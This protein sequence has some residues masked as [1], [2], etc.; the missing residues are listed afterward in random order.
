[1]KIA[2]VFPVMLFSIAASAQSSTD[3]I[4][5]KG[6]ES[7]TIVGSMAK[8]MPGAGQYIG[9][10]K[11]AQLNQTNINNVLR[12]IPG[13]NIRDE[14]GFGLRP[15]IGLR[16]TPVNRS[17]KITLMEDGIL[18]APAP[19]ADPSAY[20]FPTFARMHGIEVLKGSS[21]IKYGPYTIGGAINLLSTVIPSSFKGFAQLSYGSF[22]TNQQRIWLGNSSK[23]FDYVF[24]AN[25]LAS[26]GFKKLS[27]GANTGFDRRDVMLKLRWHTDEKAKIY[28]ALS[29]KY[30]NATEESNETYLGLIYEDYKRNPFLRY[31]GTQK[32]KLDLKHNHVSLN[33]AIIPVKNL[34][35]HTTFYQNNTYRDWARANTFGGQSIN[36]ILGDPA[37]HATSYQIMKGIA[38]GEIIYQN[39]PRT[40]LALGVQTNAD[41][42]F[43]TC[44][45][46]HKLQLGIRYH[47]D[48]ADRYATFATYQMTNGTLVETDAGVKGNQENQVRNANSLATFISYDVSY[49]GLKLSPGIRYEKI[50]LDFQNYGTEDNARLGTA[51]KSAQNEL[52]I[53]LPGIGAN[54]EIN[55]YMSVFA[56][57]HKGFSPP[58]VPSVSSTTGQANAEESI[59]YELGYRVEKSGFS[60]QVVG[61]L[62]DYDNILG[63]D[64]ISGGGAGTG[65][66]F[67]AGNAKIKGFE[68]HVTY[69]LLHKNK[70]YSRIKIPINIAYTY[71][72]AMF[73]ETFVNGGGDWGTGTIN[74]GYYIPFITPHLFTTSIGFENK[75]FNTTLLCRYTGD[76]R[77]KPGQSSLIVPNHQEKY[78]DVNT[79]NGFLIIDVSANYKLSKMFIVFSTINNLLNNKAIIANLPQGYRPNMPLS[80]NAGLKANI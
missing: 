29:V 63:S 60:G 56:G 52:S 10:Q 25:R 7:V 20:Y 36:N 24:E 70:A 71:T 34:S 21:Q 79:L 31:S 4:K 5:S 48:R 33:H 69:N 54:Y 43:N 59:N 9:A 27:N 16:G 1:M 40:F 61:F 8:S 51:L 19:Y 58:G 73:Q 49:K 13:V 55:P 77:T 65:D 72:S 68:I 62:N 41:Y 67:N 11:L 15:N 76:T 3:T 23:N 17:A 2:I 35:I 30:V 32:D 42:Q 14:E 50:H 53:L 64:N 45:L 38:N 37:T 44:D 6:L 75:K 78:T 47:Q 18:I 39:A 22:A 28:Q 74:K 12:I 57:I 66:L 80:F 46:N 26:N